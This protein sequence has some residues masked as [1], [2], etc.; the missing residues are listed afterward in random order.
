MSLYLVLGPTRNSRRA[1]GTG[2]PFYDYP[3][4]PVHPYHELE[5]PPGDLRGQNP[6]TISNYTPMQP[7]GSARE[8]V[9]VPVA[10]GHQTVPSIY[11]DDLP[12]EPVPRNYGVK[13]SSRL[14]LNDPNF[15]Y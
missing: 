2:D 5:P 10:N 9:L 15:L 7:V 1:G 8:A 6:L 4:E 14:I 12:N 13:F 3:Q 11:D